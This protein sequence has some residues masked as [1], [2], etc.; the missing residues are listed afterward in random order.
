V[1]YNCSGCDTTAVGVDAGW[2]LLLPG[3][4]PLSAAGG[5]Q[6]HHHILRVI[7]SPSAS[8][9]TTHRDTSPQCV[10]SVSAVRL[11][12]LHAV[13]PLPGGLV[14]LQGQQLH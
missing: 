3:P 5:R 4:V 9:H 7:G 13:L 1:G 12:R 6:R 8:H 11:T 2:L 14:P 10:S